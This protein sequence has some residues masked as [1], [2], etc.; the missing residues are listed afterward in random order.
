MPQSSQESAT[1]WLSETQTESLG[2]H[3]NGLLPAHS[4][5]AS[6]AVVP[7]Q[8]SLQSQPNNPPTVQV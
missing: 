4:P 5:Q 7:P 6:T 8:T 3:S 1:H 2:K